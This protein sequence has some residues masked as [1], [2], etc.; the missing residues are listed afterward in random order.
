MKNKK[1]NPY[2]EQ[3]EIMVEAY[4]NIAKQL[5]AF[6]RH[7]LNH[8]R[9]IQNG[10]GIINDGEISDTLNELAGRINTCLYNV[11][12]SRVSINFEPISK[13]VNQGGTR[14]QRN[15]DITKESRDYTNTKKMAINEAQLRAFVSESI[16]KVL[17]ESI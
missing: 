8:I 13:K 9:I 12:D 3:D 15:Y 14:F 17:R 6:S 7:M 10:E 16:K 5:A 2:A 1:S 11:S 4:K